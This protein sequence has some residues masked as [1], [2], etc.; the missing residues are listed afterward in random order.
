MR[1]IVTGATGFVGRHVVRELLSKGHT[2][3]AVTRNRDKSHAMSWFDMVEWVF[4][5]IYHTPEKILKMTGVP[6]ALIHLAWEGLPNYRGFFHINRNLPADLRFLEV[7]VQAGVP[8]LVIAGTCLE[9]GLCHGPLTE[10]MATHPI[11]PYGFAKDT[12]R[13]SL[14]FLQKESPF[15][16]QWM[17]LFYMYGEGQN[18]NS[19]LAKLDAAIDAGDRVF[20]MSVGDQLRDY[21]PVQTVAQNFVLALESPSCQGVINCA[22]G[23]PVSVLDLVHQRC[24]DKK[25]DI[26]L[27]RGMYPYTDYEPMAFW[28]VPEKLSMMG[29]SVDI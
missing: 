2:V 8:H 25:S 29:K 12:L 1:V 27:N 16:F 6:E 20:N 3:V 18:S 11:T 4:C 28:G 24:K 26:S 15:I 10:S 22:S 14:E 23:L 7:M 17:R 5:D 21:L 9:Y 13:K 19:L